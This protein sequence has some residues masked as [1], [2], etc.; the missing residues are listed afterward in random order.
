MTDSATPKRFI[1]TAPNHASGLHPTPHELRSMQKLAQPIR[2]PLHRRR[3]ASPF[4]L[5]PNRGTDERPCKD[6]EDGH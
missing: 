3:P 1:V 6:I 2:V 5:A 4:P